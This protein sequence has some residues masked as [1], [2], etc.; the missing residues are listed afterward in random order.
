MTS[1]PE[2][3]PGPSP[4]GFTATTTDDACRVAEIHSSSLTLTPHFLA[5][6][7]ASTV[8][9]VGPGTAPPLVETNDTWLG[10]TLSLPPW[11]P[12]KIHK[13][14]PATN[15]AATAASTRV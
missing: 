9:V 4:R 12:E 14:P 3:V 7:E 1:R 10:L 15:T 13:I 2:Y 5:G 11:P 8:T 6:S